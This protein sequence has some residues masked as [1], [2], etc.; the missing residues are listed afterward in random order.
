MKRFHPVRLPLGI[1]AAAATCLTLANCGCTKHLSGT[2]VAK[3]EGPGNGAV[4]D[5]LD[6]TSDDSVTVSMM[7]QVMQVNYK[8][9]GPQVIMSGNG[10]QMVFQIDKD[11]CLDGGGQF[12]KFCKK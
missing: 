2:Y 11:G 4:T 9:D 8:L 1:L 5:K 3:G 10:Q 7:Q 12:G 6:F